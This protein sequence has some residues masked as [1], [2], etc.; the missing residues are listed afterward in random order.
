MPVQLIS[1]SKGSLFIATQGGLYIWN[2]KEIKLIG[3][4]KFIYRL[5]LDNQNNLWAGE[6]GAGLHRYSVNYA[7]A[8]IIIEQKEYIEQI[9][10]ELPLLK[11]IRSLSEDENGNIFV[12]TRYNGL[13]ILTIRNNSARLLHHFDKQKGLK[14]DVIWSLTSDMFGNTWV[15]TGNGLQSIRK[16]GDLWK[17]Q[18]ENEKRQIYH[19]NYVLA[20][21]N[22]L[23]LSSQPGA[24]RF[25][26]RDVDNDVPF[27]VELLNI[28]SGDKTLSPGIK[29][30][31]FH[32][33]SLSF[34]F[35]ANSFLDEK[36]IL[37]S[38][39]ML[40]T[41]DTNWS[42][43][44]RLHNV[45]YSSLLP[46]NYQFQVKAINVNGKPSSNLA[47]YSFVIMKPFWQTAWFM[48][49]VII[50]MLT[51]LYFIY[52]YRL[53]QVT[54]LHHMRNTIS[55]D[56]HDDIGASL[57]NINIL[58]EL[59]KRNAGNREKAIDYLQKAGED[60][61][62]ISESLSDIVWNI[63]PKYDDLENLFVRMKRYAADMMEGKG[64]KADLVFPATQHYKLTMAMDKRRDFY[65]IF[66]EA[67]N[68]LVKYS[69]SANAMVK[70]ELSDHTINLLVSDEGKGF[71]FVKVKGGNG[72][73][74]MYQRAAQW[75]ATL[76]I[77]SSP[78][79]GTR[80]KMEMKLD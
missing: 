47:G 34:E 70:V 67:V 17:L 56:L 66:K 12:G 69:G 37:Y 68:N 39:R 74:N 54:K 18:D 7:E 31:P 64:I 42:K 62:H 15:A 50:A 28:R 80:I 79:R 8:D 10:Q 5:M 1:D 77:D 26:I 45:Y 49:L 55:R 63:N 29:K 6:F 73:Q 51:I 24:I 44:V 9:N 32:S 76:V 27:R 11:Q 48:G 20:D 40:G 52:R 3:G 13:F 30:F 65:L 41:A 78:G 61:Q 59:A 35:S 75:N 16:E 4:K 53:K 19:I 25:K 21:S 43:P 58:T 36:N 22:Y 57:S 33:N 71:E 46:G 72:I 2:K 23:W 38:Y 14:S 60:I